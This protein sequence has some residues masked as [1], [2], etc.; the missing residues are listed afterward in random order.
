M[1]TIKKV[2]TVLLTL[3]VFA[4]FALPAEIHEAAGKGDRQRVEELLKKDPNLVNARI[5]GSEDG[6]AF[7]KTPLHFAAEAGHMDVVKLLIEYKADVNSRTA[8]GFTPLHF[9]ALQGR[10]AAAEL[11]I[12]KKC[13]LDAR[14]TFNITP[15]FLAASR[16]HM[17]IVELLLSK[18]MD[19][20]TKGNNGMTLL[21][22]AALGGS[23][24]AALS[25]SEKGMNVNAQNIFGKN[26]MHFAAAE[27]HKGVVELLTAKGA[28]LDSKSLD[29]STAL[30]SAAAGKHDRIVE[31]LKSKGADTKPR[32]FPVLK[33][34]YL[35]QK[36]PGKTPEIFAPGIVSTD[37]GEFAGI[38]SPDHK[39]FYFT[40]S[41]GEK[42]LK[43]NTILVTKVVNGDWTEPET[44]SFSGQYFDFEPF[45]SPD[46]KKLYFGT[47]RPLEG[48][49]KQGGLQQWYME[50]S[51]AG[52][53]KPKPLSGPF[54]GKVVIY[55]TAA[56]NGNLYF[57][58]RGGIYVSVYKDGKYQKPRQLS[59]E[60][61]NVF[62]YTA[63]PFIAPDESY[64]IFDA[65]PYGMYSDLF[66]CFRKKDGTWTRARK[67]DSRVNSAE[68]EMCPSVSPDGKYFFF[69]RSK[70]IYWVDAKIISALKPRK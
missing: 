7:R 1:N 9:A 23:V 38:F 62:S 54:S 20:N 26:P 37:G 29:G 57:S 39:E 58:S 8:F 5:T 69:A 6:M 67:F 24:S 14:N 3:L 21:H 19:I 31:F 18:G 65:H 15:I 60:T 12:A 2:K 52:W 11:L 68:S 30:H 50:R 33:G 27:G 49:G 10:K 70:N 47:M 48:E 36:K 51:T 42:R 22:A 28:K 25:L 56:A 17:E 46:G 34:K 59:E 61:V 32:Q 41:G 45:I 43:T 40:R 4:V 13:K 16:G 63:H 44:A 53:N 64:L 66:V 55:L 35:G